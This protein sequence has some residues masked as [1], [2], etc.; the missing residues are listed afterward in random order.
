MRRAREAR[1][2]L[3]TRALNR[4]N[5]AHSRR[6]LACLHEQL[7]AARMREHVA[8]VLRSYRGR[9]EQQIPRANAS[10]CRRGLE[11]TMLRPWA[12]VCGAVACAKRGRRAFPA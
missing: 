9:P 8:G 6:R 11:V 7:D 12:V 4:E 5:V 2:E 10:P 1:A 3:Q